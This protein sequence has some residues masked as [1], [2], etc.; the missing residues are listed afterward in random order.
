MATFPNGIFTTI[1]EGAANLSGGQLQR[2]EIARVL[3]TKPSFLIL[4]EATNTIEATVEATLLSHIRSL[5]IT[6]LLISHR[7][8][9][10]KQCDRI[11]VLS[12]GK[13][14]Q[15]GTH[16]TLAKTEGPYKKLLEY[17]IQK[18]L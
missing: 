15:D 2:L 16:D 4:D 13:I 6:T 3:L 12:Q 14:E 8:S 18:K 10:F 9:T 7:L 17:E 11:L 1:E 5:G